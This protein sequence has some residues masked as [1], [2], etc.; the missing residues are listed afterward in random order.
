MSWMLLFCLELPSRCKR[1]ANI[2]SGCK[3]D[4]DARPIPRTPLLSLRLVKLY[5]VITEVIIR[6]KF[7]LV[8]TFDNLKVYNKSVFISRKNLKPSTS[9]YGIGM[10]SRSGVHAVESQRL[11]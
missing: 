4:R 11:D 8:V 7:D 6:P 10:A 5:I 1:V 9:V 2:R 3:T